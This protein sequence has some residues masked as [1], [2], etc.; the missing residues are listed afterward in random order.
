RSAT[1]GSP[2]PEWHRL[3]FS[4]E[5]RLHHHGAGFPAPFL[6]SAGNSDL[7]EENC[8]SNLHPVSVPDNLTN[9]LINSFWSAFSPWAIT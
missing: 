7:D 1:F 9:R 3:E 5:R 2:L 6:F 4:F 8:E